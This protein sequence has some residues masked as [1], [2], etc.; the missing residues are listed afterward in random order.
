MMPIVSLPA[1]SI[2]LLELNATP[3]EIAAGVCLSIFL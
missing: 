3:G 1:K 2:K